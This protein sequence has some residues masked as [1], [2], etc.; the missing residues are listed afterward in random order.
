MKQTRR[1]SATEAMTNIG[2]GYVVA[3]VSQIVIFPVFGVH[4]AFR[5]NLLIGIY[6]TAVSLARS[7]ALR[8][9]FTAK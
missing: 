8:R 3:V 7:Y 4:I 5:D 6:F 2:V 9:W 1:Q